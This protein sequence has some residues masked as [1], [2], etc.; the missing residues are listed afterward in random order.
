M[1]IRRAALALGLAAALAAARGNELPCGTGAAFGA[2]VRADYAVT[3]SK[4]PLALAGDGAVV[5][6]R[7]G[8]RYTM[9]SSL[10]ALG[11]F[12]AK[13]HSEGTIGHDGLVPQR[14]THRAGNRPPLAVDIDWS[15]RRVTFSP[16]GGAEPAQ[17]RMQDRLSLLA[18]LAWLMRASPQAREFDVPVAGNRRVLTYSFVSQGA[19]TIDLPAGRFEAVKFERRASSRDDLLEVWLAPRLCSLPVRVRYRD[20]R[21]LVVDQRLRAVRTLSP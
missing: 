16:D 10:Q 12:E 7:H 19:E 13:Q 5:F 15:A 17:P 1:T 14:F 9:T 20:D 4:P 6:Q 18:Q 21:G 2:S 8:G 3:A 11:L